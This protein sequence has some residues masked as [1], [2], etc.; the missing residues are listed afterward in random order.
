MLLTKNAN[1]IF[2]NIV[3]GTDISQ[4]IMIKI[5]YFYFK[6]LIEWRDVQLYTGSYTYIFKHFTTQ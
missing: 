1:T 2:K 5:K 4:F 6:T 3:S